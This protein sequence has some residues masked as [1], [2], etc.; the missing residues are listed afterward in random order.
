MVLQ[1]KNIRVNKR[2]TTNSEKNV[3]SVSLGSNIVQ[4]MVKINPSIFWFIGLC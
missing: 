3:V 1:F 4:P 2:K